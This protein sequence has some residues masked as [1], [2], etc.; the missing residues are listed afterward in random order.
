MSLAGYTEVRQ[1]TAY[2]QPMA[3]SLLLSCRCLWTVLQCASRQL[4]W[5][6]HGPELDTS[7]WAPARST[8]VLLRPLC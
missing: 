5:L 7:S 8:A 3:M 2:Q 4:C 1:G 6:A